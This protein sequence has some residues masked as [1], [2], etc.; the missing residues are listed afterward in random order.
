MT[1]VTRKLAEFSAGLSLGDLPPE[2]VERA[3]LLVLDTVG[4]ALRARHDTESTPSLLAAAA[5]L[6][7][8]G[9]AA[10][11]IGD[12]DTYA[13]PGA[14]LINGALAHSLDFD[15]THARGSIHTSAPI[16]PAALAAAEMAGA[17][18]ARLLA[19]IVAGYEVQIRLSMALD[20]SEHYKRGFHPTATCGAFG[21]TAAA[22]NIFGL[23]A[24]RIEQAF[25]ICLS[26]AAGSLQF[27]VG[28]AWTKR[29]QV[30]HASMCGLNSASLA[31]EGFRGPPEAIEGK[32]GFLRA[33]APDADPAKAIGGLGEIWE[34][35][36]IG[37][38]PYPSCRFGHAAVDA[39]L[40]LRATHEI[41]AD[42]IESVEIGLPEA[43]WSIVGNP[44]ADKQNP[45]NDVEGQFSMPFVAA[46]ALRQGGFEW[47]DYAR[48]LADPETLRLCAR[49]TAIV[50]PQ[51]QAEYP[52]LMSGVARVRTPRG[53]FE[54]F[55]AAPK[56]EP[57]NFVTATELRAKFDG[58]I[59]PYLTAGARDDLAAAL[60]ALETADDIGAL[61]RM[62]CPDLSL[63][64]A[65]GD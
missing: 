35:M 59:G 11:V 8:T 52:A 47:D 37:V 45:K 60:L 20:P 3:K 10:T 39:L 33:Y 41:D 18:G 36:A 15:D 62:T 38:K 21:A 16:L 28:G 9:G 29:F 56:G 2:V 24:E 48:H 17:D 55:V 6:G 5:K 63:L 34:T 54:K 57:E 32:H 22:A 1:Q 61:L 27:L 65:V 49:V 44:I 58:L 14:A 42:E 30:G 13:P 51:A 31:S 43:G 26:Q 25:G 12:S 7:L 53:E 4:I 46:V 40:E 23:D 50:D 19:A 64:A